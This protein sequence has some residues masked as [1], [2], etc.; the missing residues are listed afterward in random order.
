MEVA[1]KN[2]QR[3]KRGKRVRKKCRFTFS[4]RFIITRL[5][6]KRGSS[7]YF[8]YNLATKTGKLEDIIN[9]TRS[10]LEISGFKSFVPSPRHVR[11]ATAEIV[12][13][14]RNFC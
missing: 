7:E 8:K 14:F 11:R 10:L 13:Q 6:K 2:S 1:E 5:I 4:I 12:V 3:I 9:T